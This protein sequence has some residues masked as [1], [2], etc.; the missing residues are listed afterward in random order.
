MKNLWITKGTLGSLKAKQKLYD[1]FLK[2][3]TCE[4][5]ISYKNYRKLSESIKQRAKSQ[6]YSKM[7]LHHKDNTKKL[8]KL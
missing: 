5:D 2:S 8:G 4:L 6:G 3:K 1:K 7:L